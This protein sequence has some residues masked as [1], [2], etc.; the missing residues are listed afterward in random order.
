MRTPK[1]QKS[2]SKLICES[3]PCVP[4]NTKNHLKLNTENIV[5]SVGQSA[6]AQGIEKV[7]GSLYEEVDLVDRSAALWATLSRNDPYR[8]SAFETGRATTSRYLRESTFALQQA[9]LYQKDST[10]RHGCKALGIVH[11]RNGDFVDGCVLA[12]DDE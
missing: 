1:M 6:T 4:T 5:H 9:G 2:T 10:Y 8:V 3:A 7:F 12:H 11:A